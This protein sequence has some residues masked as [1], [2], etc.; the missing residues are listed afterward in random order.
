MTT[1]DTKAVADWLV[2]GARSAA[3]TQHVVGELCGRLLAC[4]VPISRVGL[5]ILTLHP[6]IMGQRFL[7]KPGTAVDVNSAPFE[8]FQTEDFRQSP[9]R[10]VI[11]TG[12]PV[13]RRLADK[14]CPIDFA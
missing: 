2:D 9:V 3:D 14:D 4:G 10:R 5:F 12:V 1:S 11:D 7:W 13:R 6:Q 8:A